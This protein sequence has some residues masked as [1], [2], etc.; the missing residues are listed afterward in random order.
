MSN[1]TENSQDNSHY[2]VNFKNKEQTGIKNE[3]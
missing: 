3:I 1:L 2:P